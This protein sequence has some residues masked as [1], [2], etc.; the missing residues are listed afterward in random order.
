MVAGCGSSDGAGQAGPSSIGSPS[1]AASSA[2]S[3]ELAQLK[4]EAGIADCPTSDP[5][6]AARADG[7]PDVTLDC[8]GGG[9]EVRLAGLRGTPMVINIWAQWCRPC[10]QEAPHLA[11]LSAKAGDKI[12]FLGIDYN[13]PDPAAAIQYAGMA[14]WS[15]PQLQDQDQQLKAPLKIL[16]PP[17]T[18]FVDADGKI[19]YRHNGPYT[20]DQQLRRDIDDHLGVPL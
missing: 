4:K 8:L 3:S 7:L 16:G 13:D 10:R 12:N 20:S 5:N 11:S 2:S 15:Y 17:Q 1:S 14:D 9:R 18:F 6:V 19:T